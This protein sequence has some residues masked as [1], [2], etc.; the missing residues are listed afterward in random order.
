MLKDKNLN[1]E[2]IEKGYVKISLL[3]DEGVSFLLNKLDE[4]KP[5]SEF[6]SNSDYPE[7]STFYASN[8]SQNVDFK[9][10]VYNSLAKIFNPYIDKIL[11]GYEMVAGG[12]F[13]KAVGT[14]Y[15]G[16]HQH[17]P[18]TID[19]KNEKVLVLWCP[20]VDVDESNGT[21]QVLEGSHNII[22]GTLPY[23]FPFPFTDFEETIKQKSAALNVKAG[24][25]VIFDDK[26]IHWSEANNSNKPRI[27][28]HTFCFPKKA[29]KI[30]CYYT[31]EQPDEFEVFE[32]DRAFYKHNRLGGKIIEKPSKYKSLGFTK[33]NFQP[34][35]EKEYFELIENGAEMIPKIEIYSESRVKKINNESIFRRIKRKL[36]Q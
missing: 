30:F 22:P 4:L 14:G 15:L 36:F 18:T 3:S 25:C 21:L 31:P 8:Y 6:N 32:I 35:S 20:L 5:D 19:L 12:F 24:E 34:L 2:L 16:P 9:K 28:A 23:R 10:Q 33:N 26:L 1:N 29:Q 27:I 17:F 7:Y 11:D 13:I